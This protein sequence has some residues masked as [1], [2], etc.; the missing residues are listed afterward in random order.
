MVNLSPDGIGLAIY[1]RST[2]TYCGYNDTGTFFTASIIKVVL[3]GTLL[4]MAEDEGRELT[5]DEHNLSYAAITSSDNDAATAIQD[6]VGNDRIG[7]FLSAVGTTGTVVDS[8][9]GNATTT[10]ADQISLLRIL[11]TSG[12]VLTDAHR[13]YLL[14]LMAQVVADQHWG[15]PA[16][17]P[18]TMAWHVKNGWYPT[19]GWVNSI[20][21]FDGVG[22]QY[23]I[24][25]LTGNS[26]DLDAGIKRVAGVARVVHRALEP[27]DPSW[28]T[29]SEGAQ[30]VRVKTL[31]HLLNA[32]GAGLDPDGIFGPL[33]GDAV[34]AFQSAHGL[35]ADGIVGPQTWAALV[36]ELS[37]GTSGDPVR[38]VQEELVSCGYDVTV[39]GT[40]DAA[41]V[42]AVKSFEQWRGMPVDGVVDER[43]WEALVT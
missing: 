27:F 15:A 6:L 38:G 29:L 32:G 8:S 41:T 39:S 30:G 35:A 3:V 4:R 22:Q 7:A 37:A 34:A 5:T 36:P 17:A 2:D 43:T 42:A 26:Y 18:G 10:A 33:T 11:N 14:D 21:S 20:A 19:D 12:D 13:A 28:R 25:I 24:A 31:Q 40:F 1:D 16:G 23:D 9:W